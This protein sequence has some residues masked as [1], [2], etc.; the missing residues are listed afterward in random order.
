[1]KKTHTDIHNNLVTYLSSN[2]AHATLVG[3]VVTLGSS[4]EQDQ[5]SAHE[6]ASYIIQLIQDAEKYAQDNV[7]KA[8]A[9]A[10]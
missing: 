8:A 5:E 3:K 1:M 4:P 9:R 6:M 7:K 2:G 10:K